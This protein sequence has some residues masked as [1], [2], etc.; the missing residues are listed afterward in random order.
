MKYCSGCGAELIDEAVV[1]IKCGRSA[2]TN[3]TPQVAGTV[4]TNDAPNFGFAILGFLFPIVGLILFLVWNNSS[5][6]K[7]KSC[8][9]GALTGFIIQI[10][11]SVIYMIAF[12]GIVMSGMNSFL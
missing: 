5:P 7:A 1:C 3:A 12:F 11:F 6:K 2:V 10:V 8:G 9:K 4:N